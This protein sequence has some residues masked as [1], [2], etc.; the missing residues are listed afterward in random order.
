MFSVIEQL[1]D[2][3][4]QWSYS[5]SFFELSFIPVVRLRSFAKSTKVQ[6]FQKET[7]Q[8]IRQVYFLGVRKFLVQMFSFSKLKLLIVEDNQ[9]QESYTI[10]WGQELYFI[11]CVRFY[12]G[13]K[14]YTLAQKDNKKGF[15]IGQKNVET[16]IV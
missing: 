10:V 1:A 11:D 16:L 4:S 2:H 3:L 12:K 13:R 5:A 8:L 7:R 15:P 9:G 14:A 6:R